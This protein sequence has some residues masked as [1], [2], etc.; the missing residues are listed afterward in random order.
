MYSRFT[1]PGLNLHQALEL[2]VIEFLAIRSAGISN[3]QNTFYTLSLPF[4]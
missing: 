1:G 4:S 3:G 2:Q